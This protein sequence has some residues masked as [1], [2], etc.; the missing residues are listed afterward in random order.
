MRELTLLCAAY[1]ISLFYRGMIAVIATDIS[2]DLALDE[3]RLG[4]LASSFFLSFALAQIPTGIVLDRFGGRLTIGSFMWF[5]VLGIGLFSI[6]T[7]FY[8]AMIGQVFIGIGCAP[9]FTGTMLIIGRR[10]SPQRFAYI[11]AI[12]IAIGSLGDLMGT[13]PLA[14]IAQWLGWRGSLQLIMLVT[15]LIALWCLIGLGKDKP[16]ATGETLGGMLRGMAKIACIRGLWPLMPIFLTSYA[17]LMAVRGVWSGP[18]LA[19]VFLTDATESGYIIMA[20]SISMALGTYLLG[21]LDRR[22]RATKIIVIFTSGLAVLP[23]FVLAAYPDKGPYFAMSAFILLGLFGFN[24]P[25]LMSHSRTFLTPEYH[26]R[27]M[28]VLT[29][30]SFIGIAITQSISGLILAVADAAAFSPTEQY[31]IL[32]IFFATIISIATLVYCFSERNGNANELGRI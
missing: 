12:V 5:A 24:Y 27:G 28:A 7:D 3:F 8:L 9:I 6:A 32:F 13:T 4:L 14:T 19:N 2:L 11:T 23:L 17:V 22:F 31:Q 21:S 25:L 10:Y 20:M 16:L 26:G 1:S 30:I 29:A 18:Y 15:A